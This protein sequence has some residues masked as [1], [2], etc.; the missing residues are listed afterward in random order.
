M[1]AAMRAVITALIGIGLGLN[2]WSA[3][4]QDATRRV[5]A[6]ELLN[7][8]DMKANVEKSFAMIKKM[9]PAQAE[10]MMKAGKAGAPST[11][12]N[13]T[14]RAG[15][16][17][18]NTMAKVMDIVGQ[19]LT[20]DKMKDDYVTIYAETFTEEEL[21][22]AIAFYKSPAGKA[23][24]QKMPEVM[25]RSMELSQRRMLTLMPKIMAITT[26]ETKEMHDAMSK[27]AG[28]APS[29]DAEPAPTVPPVKELP[30]PAK[31]ASP[32]AKKPPTDGK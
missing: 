7:E 21:K 10:A 24:T 20:W 2:G 31:E 1:E 19:E 16:A 30:P 5:L 22:G 29:N 12:P 4:A 13:A 3:N 26:K 14:K 23:L 9:I 17:V 27:E 6:E 28:A 32:P 25:R 15:K 18:D 8:M 11:S